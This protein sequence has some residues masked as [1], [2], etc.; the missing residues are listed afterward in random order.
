M[1]FAVGDSLITNATDDVVRLIEPDLQRVRL[2]Q[3]HYA[4]PTFD[5]DAVWVLSNR[6]PNRSPTVVRVRLDGTVV[7]QITLPPVAQPTAGV[8]ASVLVS[9]PSGIHAVSGDGVRRL[10][11]SGELVAVA[12][13]QLAWLDCAA[14]LSCQIVIGTFDDP[15]QVR[16]PLA[17]VEL[18]GGYFGYPLGGFSPDGRLLAL[19]LYRPDAQQGV[20][21]TGVAIIDTASGAE[22]S[23]L[24]ERAPR[25]FA[26]TALDW[27]PDSRLLFLTLDS[28][29]SV[30]NA[31]TG[32][33]RR[34]DIGV[35]QVYGLVVTGQD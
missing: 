20:A 9:T 27:S 3:N 6:V 10:T 17:P 2:A 19:P 22:L 4:L 30:W 29:V 24:Q 1:L 7:D 15:D 5:D 18:P 16:R 21:R 8:G 34:L 26:G 31:N 23:R 11:A 14:D 28:D 33:L 25:E 32:E 35:P 13:D 12:P